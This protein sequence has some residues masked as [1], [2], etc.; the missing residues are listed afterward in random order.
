MFESDVVIESS[1]G[2][3]V[4]YTLMNLLLRYTPDTVSIDVSAPD[5]DLAEQGASGASNTPIIP[6]SIS[7]DSA[8]EYQNPQANHKSIPVRVKIKLVYKGL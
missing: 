4:E 8:G 6:A 3:K 7:N 2:K 5:C 1:D